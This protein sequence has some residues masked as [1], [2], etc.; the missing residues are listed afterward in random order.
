MVKPVLLPAKT[1]VWSKTV[2]TTLKNSRLKVLLSAAQSLY[3]TRPKSVE[4]L[5]HGKEEACIVAS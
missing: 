1:G 4:G 5:D 3:H 2:A